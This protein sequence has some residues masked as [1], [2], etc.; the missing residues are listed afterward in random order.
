MAIQLAFLDGAGVTHPE[1]YWR[2]EE[3][4]IHVARAVV[5][6]RVSIY[7]S[8]MTRRENREPV[9]RQEYLAQDADIAVYFSDTVLKGVGKSPQKQSYDWLKTL[10]SLAGSV[11]V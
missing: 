7:H 10:P 5:L 1:A 11:D 2:I 4:Q 9:A 8:A 6:V 3:I